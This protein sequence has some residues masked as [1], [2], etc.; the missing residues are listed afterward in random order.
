[1]YVSWSPP[2][3]GKGVRVGWGWGEGG[4]ISVLMRSARAT[5]IVFTMT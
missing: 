5:D 2:L 4:V 1:M 3:G